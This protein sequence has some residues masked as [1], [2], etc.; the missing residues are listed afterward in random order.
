MPVE[1]YK[2][3]ARQFPDS[4]QAFDL[5]AEAHN[6]SNNGQAAR[7]ASAKVLE[8]LPKADLSDEDK[9]NLQQRAQDRLK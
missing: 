9:R 1:V 3:Y 4:P 8:L 6:A 5:L 2:H 7:N